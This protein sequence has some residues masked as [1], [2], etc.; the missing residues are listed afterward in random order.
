MPGESQI[1]TVWL[2][3]WLGVF[4]AVLGSFFDCMV[5][6]W[7]AGESLLRGRSRCGS[8]G[9]VLGAREL[10]PLFSFIFSGGRCRFCGE[11]IPVRCF[12]SELAGLLGFVFLGLRFGLSLEL[13]QWCVLGAVLLAVSIADDEKRIIPD[14]LL[15]IAAVNRIVWFFVL[16]QPA[17]ESVKTALISVCAG[18]LPMLL[19]CLL[20]E[21]TLQREAM[22]GGDIKLMG[23][24][25]LYL[26]WTQ[27][28]L[29]LFISC[30]LG[31]FWA[32]ARRRNVDK[33]IVFGPFLSMSC[34]LTVC[35][36]DGLIEWYTGFF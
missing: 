2:L 12:L 33:A 6:R 21:K 28:L 3:V 1:L 35:F 10:V 34:I 32:A 20:M 26:N 31:L 22:G 27:M 11:K 7:A 23:V 36:A 14:K 8:C 18:P 9:H 13:G 29:T 5:C 24:F 4:G 16:G 25:A 30:M 15:I 17:W 19:L